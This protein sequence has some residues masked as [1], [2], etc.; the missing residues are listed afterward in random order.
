MK[1]RGATQAGSS[2]KS[3]CG[4]ASQSLTVFRLLTVTTVTGPAELVTQI[5][6]A[7]RPPQYSVRQRGGQQ[8]GKPHRGNERPGKEDFPAAARQAPGNVRRSAICGP[9]KGRPERQACTHRA[10]D[11][12]GADD[13]NP[14]S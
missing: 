12:T 14:D 5:L 7:S 4:K 10:F 11:K 2:A 8:V 1:V 3:A 6:R 13:R 9:E